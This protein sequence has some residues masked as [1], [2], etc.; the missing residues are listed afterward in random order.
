[1]SGCLVVYYPRKTQTLINNIAYLKIS[2]YIHTNTIQNTIPIIHKTLKKTINN[3][4]KHSENRYIYT[5][6]TFAKYSK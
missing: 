4:I 5:L 6:S 3:A 1:M 2:K